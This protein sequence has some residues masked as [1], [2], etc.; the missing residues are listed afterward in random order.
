MH[1]QE[2]NKDEF[3]VLIRRISCILLSEK[4]KSRCTQRMVHSVY[5]SESNNNA[6]SY[7]Q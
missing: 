4:T 7:L 6:E 1:L 5:R 2:K 3:H